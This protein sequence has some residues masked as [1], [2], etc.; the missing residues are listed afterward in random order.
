MFQAA[1]SHR[2][3]LIAAIAVALGGP[4]AVSAQSKMPGWAGHVQTGYSIDK[5]ALKALPRLSQFS[6]CPRP[7]R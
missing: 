1:H 3:A 5:H 7:G 6:G 2:L 4:G